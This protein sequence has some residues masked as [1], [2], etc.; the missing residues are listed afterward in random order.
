M[1]YVEEYYKDNF[2]DSKDS[3]NSQREYRAKMESLK[4]DKKVLDVSKKIKEEISSERKKFKTRIEFK[5][6]GDIFFI[7]SITDNIIKEDKQ[8][9]IRYGDSKN[10]IYSNEH[11]CVLLI[12]I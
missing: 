5:V 3:E 7:L 9:D 1:K 10:N 12:D 8:C 11:E 4:K 6:V 2:K